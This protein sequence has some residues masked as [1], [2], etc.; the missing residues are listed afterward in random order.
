[1]NEL[2]E[3]IVNYVPYD[4][5]E[6]SDKEYILKFIDTF[7]DVLTRKNI[8]GHFCSSAFVVNKNRSKV[9]IFI[10]LGLGREVMLTVK[11]IYLEWL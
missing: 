6:E 3:R 1:M 10:I 9:I 11:V 2:R 7:D 4:E 5:Q 8:F